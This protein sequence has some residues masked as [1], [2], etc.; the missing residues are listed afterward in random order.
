MNEEQLQLF[1]PTDFLAMDGKWSIEIDIEDGLLEQIQ[2]TA[3]LKG[4]TVDE[5]ISGAVQKMAG[6]LTC[7]TCR[8]YRG[9]AGEYCQNCGE[10]DH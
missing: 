10:I 6:D 2:E 4:I 5:F 1:D 9:G 8:G 7:P 3:A